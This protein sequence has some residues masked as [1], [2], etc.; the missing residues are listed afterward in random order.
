MP[1]A[2]DADLP[3][4]IRDHLP[5]HARAIFRK[6][7]NSAWESYGMR[8]PWRREEIAYRV[9]WAAVKRQFEKRGEEWVPIDG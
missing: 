7:F 4:A 9:A 5:P 6:A 8:E 2:S 1:Y 3:S